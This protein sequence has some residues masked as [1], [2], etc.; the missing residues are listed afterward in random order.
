MQDAEKPIQFLETVDLLRKRLEQLQ[1]EIPEAVDDYHRLFLYFVGEQF[2]GISPEE[3]KISDQKGDQKIDF[4][5]AGED[6]F[7]AYQ[8]KLPELERLEQKKSIATFGPDLVNEAEDVLTFLT[9]NSGAAVGNEAAQAARNK[10]RSSKQTSEAENEIYQLEVILACFGRLTP[11][12]EDRLEELRRRWTNGKEEFK[13]K[14]INFDAIAE[15]FS[16][17]SGVSRPRQIKLKYKKGTSVNTNEW[18][19]AL[20]PAIEFYKLFE[21]HKMTLFDLNVRYYLERSSVNKE[22]IKSLSTTSGQ[23]RFHLLNNGVTISASSCSFSEDHLQ[24]TL[25]NPQIINGCQTVISI[26][27]GYNQMKDAFKLQHFTEN[28]YVPMRVIQTQDH[29][30]LAEVVTASNN[31]NKMSPRN[32]R[33]NSRVQRVLQRKFDM[34]Q[35][36]Y[37]Y[38]RKDGEFESIREYRQERRSTFRPKNYQYSSRD[39]REIDNENL[40]KAWLSFIGFSKD[41]SEKIKAFESMDEGGRYE[42]LFEKRPSA[43]HWRAIARSAQVLFSDENFEPYTPEPGQYLLSHLIFEFVRAYLPSP[44]ANRGGSITL[45]KGT[46][47]ITHNSSAEDINKALMDDEDYVLNQILYNMKEVIVELYA[48]ILIRA[49]GPLDADTADK[50]L[51]LP[52]IRDLYAAPDFKSFVNNLRRTDLV[53]SLENNLLFTCFEFIKEAVT[54]WKS[55]HEQEYSASQRRIRYLHSAKVVEQMKDFLSKTD[56]DTKRFG[57]PWKQPQTNFLDSLPNF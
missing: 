50:I 14:V 9:D 56:E 36:R 23:K 12:A 53:D 11:P 16:L 38:E 4:Y 57:Y 21:K 15:E 37:F 45:L 42:W 40:A 3:I 13:I 51:Q 39:Y 31:Q 8:C 7:V 1:E 54:R 47:K 20:V 22:I 25:H 18:G 49:Y 2:E 44:Q 30:L 5:D 48:W 34:L 29:S 26:F 46:G 33:S 24:V 10:Y 52:G 19:Y 35:Y 43:E 41:A 32:L 55:T 27:R 28:C 17:S 6:R